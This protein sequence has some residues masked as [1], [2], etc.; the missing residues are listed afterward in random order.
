MKARESWRIGVW[1]GAAALLALCGAVATADAGNILLVSDNG[2]SNT[3]AG[4]NPGPPNPEDEFV[5]FLTGM[6]HNVVI[7][8][9]VNATAQFRP[10]PPTAAQLGPGGLFPGSVDLIIVSRV[11]SSGDYA[12]NAAETTAW[13]S[14]TTPLLLMGPHLA[15]SSRWLWLNSTV[16]DEADV[17]DLVFDAPAHPFVN[18]LATDILFPVRPTGQ[19][20]TRVGTADAGNGTKIAHTPD[21]DVAI[22]EWAAG[23]EF[24]AGSGQ[25]AGGRRVL[26][27]GLR[28]HETA[29][30]NTDP[31]NEVS[32]SHF[33]DNGK[34]MLE[35]T[36]NVM[37]P[38]PSSIVLLIVAGVGLAG[39]GWRRRRAA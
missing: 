3:R 10:A 4:L 26:F 36:I 25:I 37:I 31:A 18:G 16:I 9:G 1:L 5:S 27:P 35:Q 34:A 6:G 24:Y 15:R 11:T 38:E 12:S 17:T 7:S 20:L 19:S 13:N 39:F 23:T 32:F 30:V 33:S 8:T 28:Y 14:I 22:V 2:W 21:G 29:A